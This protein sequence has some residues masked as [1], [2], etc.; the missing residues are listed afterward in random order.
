MASDIATKVKSVVA[1]R[2]ATAPKKGVLSRLRARLAARQDSEH[3][4]SANRFVFLVLMILYLWA[5][6]VA[7]QR[8][9]LVALGGGL[10]ITLGIFA[11][12]VWRPAVNGVR[13]SIAFCA[14]LGTICLMMYFGDSAGA[15]FYPLLLW[16]VL[17][18]G[19]RFG[20]SW[21]TGS[22]VVAVVLFLT[23]VF[24]TPFWR[25]NPS[26]AG[27]L[28]VGL[29]MIPGY[30][31]I[32]IRKLNDAR[33]VA[34]RASAAKTMFL[35]T[36]SHQLRTP[37]NAIRGAHDTLLTGKLT[38]DQ[39][40]MLS[41][42][43]NGAEILLSN[44]EELIDFS[45][46]ESG[47]LR[48]NPVTFELLPLLD[49]VMS[50][51][52]TLLQ[53]KPVRLA[54]H[55]DSRCPLRLRGERRFLRDILQNLVSNAVKFT[56]EGGV[57][58]AVRPLDVEN[59]T[60]RIQCE[61]I[62]TGIGIA[63]DALERIFDSFA[64]ANERILDEF[65]GTGLGLAICRRL[66]SALSGSVDVISVPGEGSRFRVDVL[67]D[68]PPEDQLVLQNASEQIRLRVIDDTG[69]DLAARVRQ[70]APDQVAWVDFITEAQEGLPAVAVLSTLE[71]L[72]A[73]NP[74][75][76]PSVYFGTNPAVATPDHI[77]RDDLRWH[78]VS[79][80]DPGFSR[81]DW[82]AA[83]AIAQFPLQAM[84]GRSA[85]VIPFRAKRRGIRVLVAEDNL[86]NQRVIGK[87]LETAGYDV[88]FAGNGD[89]ALEIMDSGTI[90]VVL[91]D[92]NMPTLNGLDATKHYRASALDLSHLPIIGLTAD[93]TE[94]M[95]Q[96]C[97]EAGM[98]ACVTK[99]IETRRLLSILEQFIGK[100]DAPALGPYDEPS[101]DLLSTSRDGNDSL[102]ETRLRELETLGGTNFL[103]EI[104]ST[105]MNDVETLTIDLQRAQGQDDL[106]LFR[107]VAH[108]M[109]SCAANLGAESLRRE[110][111]RLEYLPAEKFARHNAAELRGLVE[112]A[113]RLRRDIGHRL[114]HLSPPARP[115]RGAP[116]GG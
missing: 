99:P 78:C 33:Q 46:I 105:L 52:R 18:N 50:I 58:L 55:I 9:A 91:M 15:I 100:T 80:L 41:I 47:H 89:D 39:R 53:E 24:T 7:E 94:R 104:L 32:L 106:Y 21:L 72:R 111:E 82:M 30:A 56:R 90:D 87:M 76:G 70:I 36:V 26:L 25:A 5:R 10:I 69:A 12:I 59:G 63:P 113:T 51:A 84:A 108:S 43:H 81:E 85:V 115:P 102:N 65:G 75:E 6:P 28:A 60:C 11:H 101:A 66:A 35:A 92:V 110:A 38:A 95:K 54:M 37:L 22:C 103:R 88:V 73:R 114:S 79:S 74:N 71:T 3:E 68:L 109:R 116:A 62:D 19:F 31:A 27:G 96:R 2:S 67:F 64:Q 77:L 107:D 45:E 57:L 86:L 20:I 97:L 16:T 29:I 1:E 83:M 8:W 93:A 61:V 42:A 34:E 98:D 44:I 14:D 13:R 40:E 112:Q 17:G 23:V 4:M 49:E 48:H